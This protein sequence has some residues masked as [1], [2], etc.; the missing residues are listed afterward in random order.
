MALAYSI[1]LFVVFVPHICTTESKLRFI[2][3]L[4]PTENK[5]YSKHYF[6]VKKQKTN[7]KQPI[8]CIFNPNSHCLLYI[9][10]YILGNYV[11]QHIHNFYRG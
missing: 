5:L 6:I 4:V 10:T 3:P 11:E 1:N 9:L 2:K 8:Q 7:Q